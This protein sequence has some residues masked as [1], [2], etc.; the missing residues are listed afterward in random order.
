MTNEEL[1]L[2]LQELGVLE[3]D[4]ETDT[5]C[6]LYPVNNSMYSDCSLMYCTLHFDENGNIIKYEH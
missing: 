3:A 5:M 6:H 1:I 2:N 4:W